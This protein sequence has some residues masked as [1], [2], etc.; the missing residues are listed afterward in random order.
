MSEHDYPTR[1]DYYAICIRRGA[2]PVTAARIADGLIAARERKE[3]GNPGW[4]DI[5]HRVPSLIRKRLPHLYSAAS[6]SHPSEDVEDQA[7]SGLD[8]VFAY[9][10]FL[11]ML[12]AEH[13]HLVS[14][15]ERVASKK[16]MPDIWAWLEILDEQ[17][18]EKEA[19]RSDDD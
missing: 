6:M 1:D 8:A 16:S 5:T 13:G 15:A 2:H 17:R 11:G 19:D 3:S 4:E 12:L 10:I 9:G 18:E 7:R 14:E